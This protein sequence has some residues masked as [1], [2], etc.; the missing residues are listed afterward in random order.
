MTTARAA[1]SA[2]L[3]VASVPRR[4]AALREVVHL[5][6]E[7]QE[8]VLQGAVLQEVRLRETQAVAAVAPPAMKMTI[9][10]R[11]VVAEADGDKFLSQNRQN[12]QNLVYLLGSNGSQPLAVATPT[13]IGN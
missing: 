10:H 5:E 7:A 1:S 2:T 6:V 9:T 8:V 4:A 11:V 3:S 13:N 12:F